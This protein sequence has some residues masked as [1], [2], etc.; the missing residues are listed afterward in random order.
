[1]AAYT[2]GFFFLGTSKS[3]DNIAFT[4]LLLQEPKLETIT[5]ETIET[6]RGQRTEC[7]FTTEKKD[8]EDK[9]PADLIGTLT[10]KA[11][12]TTKRAG[13]KVSRKN[14]C[15]ILFFNNVRILGIYS[16]VNLLFNI[17]YL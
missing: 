8:F 14:A 9:F 17:K 12:K 6:F 1:M 7:K 5:R 13:S 3:V 11:K 4:K 15:T 16:Y 2:F 10:D